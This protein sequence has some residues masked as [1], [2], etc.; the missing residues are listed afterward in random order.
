[1]NITIDPDQFQRQMMNEMHEQQ[2]RS[3]YGSTYEIPLSSAFHRT[4]NSLDE[5]NKRSTGTTTANV[6][7]P[8]RW[9]RWMKKADVAEYLSVSLRTIDK[10]VKTAIIP[11]PIVHGDHLKRWDRLQIDEHLDCRT[12]KASSDGNTVSSVL[13]AYT[14]QQERGNI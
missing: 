14:D 3:T 12:R 8:A 11:S 4:V 13:A 2:W 5:H 10:W 9:P 6:V 1:M 7:L